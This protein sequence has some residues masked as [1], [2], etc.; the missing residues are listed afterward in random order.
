MIYDRAKFECGKWRA[1]FTA[2]TYAEAV[3]ASMLKARP[4]GT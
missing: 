2:T 3:P 4:A 1:T